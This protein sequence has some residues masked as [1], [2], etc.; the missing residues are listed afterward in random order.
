MNTLNMP[1]AGTFLSEST[2]TVGTSERACIKVY[3]G[4]MPILGGDGGE[5][6]VAEGA[7]NTGSLF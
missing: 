3:T 1:I 4:V 5:S 7:G 2:W 6:F